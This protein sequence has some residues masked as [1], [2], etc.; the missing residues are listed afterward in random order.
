MTT[1][2][3]ENVVLGLRLIR[4][5]NGPVTL[6]GVVPRPEQCPETR[7]LELRG[8]RVHDEVGQRCREPVRVVLVRH[9]TGAL[10][11]LQPGSGK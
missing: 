10:K 3:S 9:V 6:F 4:Q 5:T 7:G 11:D 8:R 2:R 1:G